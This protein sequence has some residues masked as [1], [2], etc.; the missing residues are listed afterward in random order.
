MNN[1]KL[2]GKWKDDI[3]GLQK[4]LYGNETFDAPI[5]GVNPY[6]KD[7]NQE[8]YIRNNTET[9]IANLLPFVKPLLKKGA[10]RI[11]KLGEQYADNVPGLSSL[12]EGANDDSIGTAGALIQAGGRIFPLAG[13]LWLGINAGQ[14][15][16][17]T[18]EDAQKRGYVK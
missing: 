17:G 15:S 14:T 4:Y 10:S 7:R 16:A 8:T 13:A 11:Y 5:A 6:F 9:E 18:L 2:A 12:G 1:L 3:E